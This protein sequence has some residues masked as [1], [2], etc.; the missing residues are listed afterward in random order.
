MPP[1]ENVT[2]RESAKEQTTPRLAIMPPPENVAPTEQEKNQGTPKPTIM[3]PPEDIA[4]AKPTEARLAIMPPPAK[5]TPPSESKK[6]NE[7]VGK[8]KL[9][10]AYVESGIDFALVDSLIYHT[11]DDN[12][13]LCVPENCVQDVLRIAH[14]ENYHAGHHRAYARLVKTVYIRKLSRRLTTY[15]RHC[16]QCQLNQTKRHKPYGELMPISTLAIPYHTIAIDFIVALPKQTHGCDAM[17]T[18]TCKFSKKNILI[19]GK[20]TF[21]AKQW[22]NLLLNA[23]MTGD[24]GIPAGIISDRDRKFTSD[25]WTAIFERLDTK[26]L[27]STAYHSQ[28]DGQS[29][30]TNQTIEIALRFLIAENPLINWKAALPALQFSMNN[31]QNAVTGKSPNEVTLGFKP[32]GL[33]AFNVPSHGAVYGLDKLLR[34][35]A[36]NVQL[37]GVLSGYPL[38]SPGI[39]LGERCSS[40]WLSVDVLV[41][42]LLLVPSILSRTEV[43]SI[44]QI[45]HHTPSIL[46]DTVG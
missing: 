20:T 11:K 35:A 6:A 22:G 45:R 44:H 7:D 17:M 19:P 28:T 12:I 32:R 26:L 15:I 37:D 29:E 18:T 36:F 33:N 8:L 23:L 10:P 1:P 13:R 14:D 34:A 40:R 5:G 42:S 16:P 41:R 9:D 21:T 27:M 43:F 39:R 31:S 24:W 46:L 25:I 30:R 3:P 4:P 38:R 2:P